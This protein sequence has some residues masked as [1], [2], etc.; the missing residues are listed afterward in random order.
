M[1]R[2]E[3]KKFFARL[4]EEASN[5]T[6]KMLMATTLSFR[7]KLKWERGEKLSVADVRLTLFALQEIMDGRQSPLGLRVAQRELL[8]IW[9]EALNSHADESD[10][11]N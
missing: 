6:L 8:Q 2:D 4:G 3:L 9:V 1:Q 5:S 7:D 11:E 10:T